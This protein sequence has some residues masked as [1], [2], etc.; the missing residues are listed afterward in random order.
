M[1]ALRVMVDE[2]GFR[3]L[4]GNDDPLQ[5][6]WTTPS[7][8]PW[9]GLQHL[10]DVEP[11]PWGCTLTLEARSKTCGWAPVPIAEVREVNAVL[12]AIERVLATTSAPDGEELPHGRVA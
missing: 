10:A 2:E 3:S 7:A 4:P 12:R 9:N 1:R 5:L 8:A 6:V 11:T